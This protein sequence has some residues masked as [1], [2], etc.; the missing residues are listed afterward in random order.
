MDFCIICQQQ[1]SLH[2]HHVWMQTRGGLTTVGLCAN[3]HQLIHHLATRIVA[4]IKR[5]ETPVFEW[6]KAEPRPELAKELI[7]SVVQASLAPP[8]SYRV[9]LDL[10]PDQ[11]A[12]LERLKKDLGLSS[13]AK[14]VFA[15]LD[16][17][18]QSRF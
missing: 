1:H 13:L 15:A 2:Q 5:N 4:Q 18:Y 17:L 11:R 9:T 3:H 6:P 16:Y 14:T 8:Q 10:D 12:K 7:A